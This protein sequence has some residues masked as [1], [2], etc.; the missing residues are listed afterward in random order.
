MVL[1]LVIINLWFIKFPSHRER[2]QVTTKHED[3]VVPQV[4]HI[5]YTSG[6]SVGREA[7][8]GRKNRRGEPRKVIMRE[9]CTPLQNLGFRRVERAFF[10][11]IYLF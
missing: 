11:L 3:A 6:G 7:G 8:G 9:L 1:S 4:Q 2:K 10:K 5:H